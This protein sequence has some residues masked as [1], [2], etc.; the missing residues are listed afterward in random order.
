MRL[1]VQICLLSV[2]L[3]WGSA[4]AWADVV[5]SP[6]KK[7]P[8]GTIGTTSHCGPECVVRKCKSNKQCWGGA[9][10]HPVVLCVQ[11]TMRPACGRGAFLNKGKKYPVY[12]GRGKC[13][14]KGK[15]PKGSKCQKIKVCMKKAKPTKRRKAPKKSEE[16]AVTRKP[17][18]APARPRPKDDGCSSLGG[19]PATGS[20]FA[21][22]CLVM[23]LCFRRRP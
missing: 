14:P 10:C 22:V 12:Y 5:M 9:T 1:A 23:G 20:L 21:L 11:K 3:V 18:K 17:A 8:Y 7:C 16:P 15:C 4:A 2:G 19:L 13:G 6:P